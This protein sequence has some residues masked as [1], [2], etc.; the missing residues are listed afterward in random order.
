VLEKLNV[1]GNFLNECVLQV[2]LGDIALL[3]E[4]YLDQTANNMINSSDV[5]I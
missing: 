2:V 3:V 4:C 5:I 1:I